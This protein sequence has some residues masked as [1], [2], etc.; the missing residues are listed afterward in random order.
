MRSL[1]TFTRKP[2][3]SL[4]WWVDGG[5]NG[6]TVCRR[7][8]YN[9]VILGV[10]FTTLFLWTNKI[11]RE[12][13]C[14]SEK[15][16]RWTNDFNHS[17]KC[18]KLEKTIVFF[19]TNECLKRFWQE[20]YFFLNERFCSQLLKKKN[21]FFLLIKRSF[22]TLDFTEGMFTKKTTKQIENDNYE[23]KRNRFS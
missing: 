22:R 20:R 21:I 23:W 7:W 1:F 10:W 19:W 16:K 15:E 6:G 12:R 2:W 17:E 11:F 13:W 18:K 8:P 5:F 4:V 3:K 9:R 14:R